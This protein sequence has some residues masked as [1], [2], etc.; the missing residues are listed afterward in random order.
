M[1]KYQVND[2]V[3]DKSQLPFKIVKGA[4]IE[5][6]IPIADGVIQTMTAVTTEDVDVWTCGMSDKLEFKVV[7]LKNVI[8]DNPPVE[9]IPPSK[10][11]KKKS[12]AKPVPYNGFIASH[13]TGELNGLTKADITKVLG[14]KNNG[15]GEQY[16]VTMEWN[17]TYRGSEMSIWD[18][19]GSAPYKYF[20]TFGPP[21][22]FTELFGDS[23]KA[24]KY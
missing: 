15:T 8:D 5:I 7:S 9:S 22:L 19:K 6:G 18:W 17:F 3:V 24:T 20:S 14:F 1:K 11:K 23:Y 2:I 10:A 4:V 12:R 21:E 16:K 13:K